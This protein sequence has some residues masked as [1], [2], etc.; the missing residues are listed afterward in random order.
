MNLNHNLQA[1]S[2]VILIWVYFRNEVRM[3]NGELAAWGNE[4]RNDWAQAAEKAGNLVLG[5]M[6]TNLLPISIKY[7]NCEWEFTIEIVNCIILIMNLLYFLYQVCIESC[8]AFFCRC[9]S[10]HADYC[11]RNFIWRQ[12]HG[13]FN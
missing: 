3:A 13:G 4:G 2:A 1:L 6:Q 11:G 10:R 5:K 7:L 9:K 8:N 12:P